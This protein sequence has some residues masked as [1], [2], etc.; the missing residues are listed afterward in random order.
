[1]IETERPQ[2]STW[3]Q[4]ADL[5]GSPVRHHVLHRLRDPHAQDADGDGLET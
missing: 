4:T 1:M 3:E 5:V 2:P